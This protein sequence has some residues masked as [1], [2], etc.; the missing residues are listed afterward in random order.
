M[1]IKIRNLDAYTVAKI[2]E[3]AKK[4]GVSRN[5][6]LVNHFKNHVRNKELGNEVR[7]YEESLSKVVEVAKINFERMDYIEKNYVGLVNL[8]S[9]VTGIHVEELKSILNEDEK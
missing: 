9:V 5:E 8:I 4:N 6:F 2:N 7:V 1:E 3:Y